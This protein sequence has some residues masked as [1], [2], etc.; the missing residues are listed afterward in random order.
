MRVPIS[1]ALHYPE[2][3]DVAV[4]PLDL[5]EVGELTFEAPDL[6]AFP[7]LRLARE[8][9]E[10]GGTAPCVLNAA[11]EVA[12]AAFLDGR[13]PFTAIAEV[14]ERDPRG[15]AGRAA[16]DALRGPVRRR[17]RGARAAPRA[18]SRRGG[19]QRDELGPHLRRVRGPDHPARVR[20]TSRRPRRRGMRVE[21]FFLFFPPKLVSVKRGETEYGI[22]AMPLGGFVK[23]TG[24]NPEEEL[25]AEVAPR[26]YYH[27][28]VWKRIVVIAAGPAMN[29]LIAFVILFGAR[30][31]APQRARQTTVGAIEPGSPAA[32]QL[33][34]GRP[35]PRRRRQSPGDVDG[36]IGD[37]VRARATACAGTQPTTAAGR[38]RPC[39]L[40]VERDGQART[41]SDHAR[42]T[43]PTSSAC[44]S[45]SPTAP[46]PAG[47]RRRARPA[48]RSSEMWQVTTRR[49]ASSARIFEP[50]QRKQIP[51]IVGIYEVTRQAFEF[52]ARE[53][54][55]LLALISLSLGDHQPVPV[56]AA[57]RRAHLLEP[58]GEGPRPAGPVQRHGARRRDRL[59]AGDVLFAVGLSNDI[60]RLTGAGFSSRDR[61][62]SGSR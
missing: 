15:A 49:S 8:A 7:C 40:V 10:A 4:P 54:L 50:E 57:R 60:G 24:M 53:A 45:A 17:R 9:G 6:D 51:G 56:P 59:R 13:I 42:A 27:Q 29:L 38:R 19:R 46:T 25:P 37:P 33:R 36:R 14:V 55:T 30:A 32:A 3:A 34:A 52:G 61:P 20:A 39:T 22:G 5:A 16:G 31:S 26:A 21:R 44:G 18:R 11:D 1:Y 47:R 58:G 48:T 43:T 2:R 12:V 23:I 28:P 35:D 41:L 62:A